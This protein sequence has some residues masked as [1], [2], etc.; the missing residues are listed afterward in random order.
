MAARIAFCPR[1]RGRCRPRRTRAYIPVWLA[2]TAGRPNGTPA[3]RVPLAAGLSAATGADRAGTGE[4]VAGPCSP[5][6]G[7]LRR[8]PGTLRGD[9]R[10]R[11]ARLARYNLPNREH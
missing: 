6:I 5:R 2:V 7:H 9:G 4:D 8:A 11:P 1:G 3:P 10:G